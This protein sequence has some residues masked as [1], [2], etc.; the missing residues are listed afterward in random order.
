MALTTSPSFSILQDRIN[1]LTDEIWEKQSGDVYSML[2]DKHQE[3]RE[4][5]CSF[6]IAMRKYIFQKKILSRKGFSASGVKRHPSVV[7]LRLAK[8]KMKEL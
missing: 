6:C 2:L 5:F 3:N 8:N 4:C 7:L 1:R